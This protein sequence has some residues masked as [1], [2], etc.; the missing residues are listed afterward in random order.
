MAR[1]QQIFRKEALS[2]LST[3]DQLDRA[4][5]VTPSR[6]WL[7]LL[8]ILVLI[9]AAVAWSIVGEVSTYV[10]AEALLLNQGGRVVDAQARGQGRFETLAV[11]VGDQVGE[12]HVVASIVNEEVA[13]RLATAQAR[14]AELRR[15]LADLKSAVAEE[16]RITNANDAR[17]RQ[18]LDELEATARET[19]QSARDKLDEHT[20]LLEE[21]VVTRSVVERSQRTLNSARREL[22]GVLRERDSLE[23]ADIRRRNLENQRLRDAEVA[24]Q[25]AERHARE[26]ETL[27]RAQQITAPVSGRVTEIKAAPG[28]L[29]S[30]GQPVLS[31]R[32]G[33]EELEALI[34]VDGT[35]GKKV[36]AGMEALIS[37][38]TVRRE[39]YGA[40]RGIVESLSPFPVSFEGIVAELQ[41]RELARAF[42]ENGPPYSGRVSLTRDEATASGFA[43]T[44]PKASEQTLS[45]G[46]LATV[47]IKTDKQQPITLVVPLLKELLGQ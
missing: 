20:Q 34:Y 5:S 19:V 17:H 28:A 15:T 43:W 39:E 31:I 10:N 46:T 29:L 23:A 1:E 40:I 21:R 18:H 14:V 4:L 44:S 38:S 32:A 9:G 36:K 47:E 12:G 16:R 2:R 25:A 45:S 33:A 3:P 11:A 26:L 27:R 13:E 8:T 41:N 7:S 30:P 37:P 35:D 22:L 24:L 6:A 42:S